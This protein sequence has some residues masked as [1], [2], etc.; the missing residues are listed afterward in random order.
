M[1][2]DGVERTGGDG[3]RWACDGVERTGGG[4]GMRW[5]VMEWKGLEEAAA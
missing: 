1:D 3:M 4:G 5:T 2:C